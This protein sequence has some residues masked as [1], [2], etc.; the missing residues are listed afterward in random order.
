[1]HV[2][3]ME[4]LMAKVKAKRNKKYD[5]AKAQ[6]IHVQSLIDQEK[7]KAERINKLY[8][9]EMQFVVEEVNRKIDDF[10]LSN[11]WGRDQYC[12]EWVVI[13]AYEQQN[14][15]I[16]LKMTQL[17]TPEYWEVGIDAHFFNEDKHDVYTIPFYIEL[18]E[19]SHPDLMNGC[20]VKVNRGSGLKTRWKGLQAEL[21]DHWKATGIP[22]GYVLVKS[23]AHFKAHAKFL[24]YQMYT[25]HN[26][27]LHLRDE[28][29]LIT[30]LKQWGQ[31]A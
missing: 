16:A 1:M 15:I 12:P 19:M 30:G 5:P 2:L 4:Q 20:E 25:E 17:K 10:A 27:L 28:G 29:M 22:E 3:E 24:N 23:Q 21:D 26:Y 6:R 11:G 7:A 18:P 9:F 8:E 14:L 31:A 13:E